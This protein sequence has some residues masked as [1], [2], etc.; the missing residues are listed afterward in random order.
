MTYLREADEIV[1]ASDDPSLRLHVLLMHGTAALFQSEFTEAIDSIG[2]AV[3][4]LRQQND[5]G[6]VLIGEMQLIIAL[7]Y[8][9]DRV[10]VRAV[11]D[12]VLRLSDGLGE[13]W[14]RCQALWALGFDSWL[15]GD[16]AQATSFVQ[17]ALVL[18]PEFNRV[19]T[20]L[21]LELLAW[22]ATSLQQYERGLRLFGAAEMMWSALGTSVGAF[23]LHFAGHSD[24]CKEQL[25][26]HL[27]PGTFDQLIAESRA[28]EAARAVAYALSEETPAQ[29]KAPRL[30]SLTRRESE[31]AALI[32]EG[33]STR[34][35]ADSLVLSKRTVDGHIENIFSKLHF[36]SR[37][38]LVSWLVRQQYGAK[39]G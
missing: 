27:E 10:R 17:K 2:S 34:E 32:A 22:I 3:A 25:R 1:E 26:T 24:R 9:R 37:A 38:Q 11:A 13:Q 8:S 28:W 29:P 12:D 7:S 33:R 6:P 19:G 21:D 35:I 16:H 14:G 23:G 30:D 36:N 39:N 18:K 15:S 5:Y 20:A 4:G 31:V